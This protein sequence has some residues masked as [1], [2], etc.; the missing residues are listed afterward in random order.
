[1]SGIPQE[2]E[3]NPTPMRHTG[4]ETSEQSA[5]VSSISLSVEVTNLMQ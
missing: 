3:K 2:K 1:V 4:R 5:K